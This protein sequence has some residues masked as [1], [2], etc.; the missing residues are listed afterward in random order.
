VGG[1]ALKFNN[2]SLHVGIFRFVEAI[3]MLLTRQSLAARIEEG[4]PGHADHPALVAVD[5]VVARLPAREF[6]MDVNSILQTALRLLA[7]HMEM[8]S[9]R[10]SHMDLGASLPKYGQTEKPAL[11]RLSDLPD[12]LA[13]VSS[14]PQLRCH[15][16]N[17][18]PRYFVTVDSPE[19]ATA[20]SD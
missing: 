10:C 12:R 14:R 4:G 5:D 16:R 8:A 17:A 3:E 9:Q 1:A 13:H 7:P 15:V 11:A 18:T 19:D 20:D 6:R 2:P